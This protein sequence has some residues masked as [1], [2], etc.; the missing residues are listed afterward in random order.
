[1][2]CLLFVS[3]GS[4]VLAGWIDGVIFSLLLSTK[5]KC[6]GYFA[7]ALFFPLLYFISCAVCRRCVAALRFAAAFDET[8]EPPRVLS[9]LSDLTRVYRVVHNLRCAEQS[10][11]ECATAFGMYNVDSLDIKGGA[12][13]IPRLSLSLCLSLCLSLSLCVSAVG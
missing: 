12:L 5:W 13:P 1:M 6:S 10:G 7:W 8:R 4:G 2:K 11:D 3:C 9:R